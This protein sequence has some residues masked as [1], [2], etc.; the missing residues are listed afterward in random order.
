M[1]PVRVAAVAALTVATYAVG[2]DWALSSGVKQASWY[3]A[4]YAELR[5]AW[6]APD[7]ATGLPDGGGRVTWDENGSGCTR[8]VEVD[9]KDRVTLMTLQGGTCAQGGYA[10]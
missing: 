1:S 3:G 5:A 2:V 9:A 6:G 7:R 8:W 4:P 10:R